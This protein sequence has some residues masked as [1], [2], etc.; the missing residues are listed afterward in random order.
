MSGRKIFPFS[1]SS[2]KKGPGSK[3][4]SNQISD[5]S[6][7]KIA[8]NLEHVNGKDED[9]AKNFNE[10]FRS[11]VKYL[12]VQSYIGQCFNWFMLVLSV[13]SCFEFIASTYLNVHKPADLIIFDYLKV[14]ELFAAVLFAFDWT[15]AFYIAEHKILF[16][17]SFYSMVDIM[18]VIPIFTTYTEHCIYYATHEYDY[19]FDQVVF[20]ILCGLNTT[21][22][23]RALRVHRAFQYIEDEVQRCLAH[24]SLNIAVMILFS[25]TKLFTD[26]ILAVRLFISYFFYLFRCWRDA[27]SGNGSRSPFPY[28]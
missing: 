20:Y 17:S 2:S 13:L 7:K 5:P 15:I 19:S 14:S 22:I 18:T 3:G 9:A 23:L 1:S 11:F 10:R 8:E 26:Q 28:L 24:M 21:R 12:M 6:L 16:L 25:K 4:E 27:I